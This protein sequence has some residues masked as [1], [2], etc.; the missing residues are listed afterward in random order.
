MESIDKYFDGS[1]NAGTQRNDV[2]FKTVKD[3]MIM[4]DSYKLFISRLTT[5]EKQVVNIRFRKSVSESAKSMG[6]SRGR[7]AQ[8]QRNISSKARRILRDPA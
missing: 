7:M 3:L 4:P 6:V 5:R 1:Y 2:F 8:L